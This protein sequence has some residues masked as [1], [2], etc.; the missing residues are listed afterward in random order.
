MKIGP[1]L[2]L[3]KV[4]LFIIIDAFVLSSMLNSP[5]QPEITS[6][7]PKVLLATGPLSSP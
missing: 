1:E 3:G 4:L 6:A 2:I 7:T 5:L